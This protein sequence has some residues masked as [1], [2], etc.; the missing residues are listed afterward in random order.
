MIP[1]VRETLL[2][3]LSK[4]PDYVMADDPINMDEELA[5]T[6]SRL[7]DRLFDDTSAEIEKL[8]YKIEAM[9]VDSEWNTIIS[10]PFTQSE[11]NNH[12][13]FCN[14]RNQE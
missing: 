4:Y 1:T 10:S 14:I 8:N 2:K 12:V 7:V 3:I 9:E 5:I 11:Y 6:V 13:C